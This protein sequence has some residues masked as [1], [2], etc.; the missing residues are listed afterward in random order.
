MAAALL[1]WVLA[2]CLVPNIWL[3]LTEP[4]TF[5]QIVTNILLP[6]G[7]Y[8]I[9]MSLSRHIGRTSLWMI[10]VMFFA[11]FQIVLLYMYGRSIIAVDMFLNVATTNPDEVG[12]LLGNM[13]P[14]IGAI[15]II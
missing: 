7:V 15:V 9:L 11:A 4:L 8:A 13:F 12:E 14:I 1:I 2:A 3:S 10:T 6:A 5:V